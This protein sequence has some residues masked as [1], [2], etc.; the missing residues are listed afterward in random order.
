M[1]DRP[2]L[3][4]SGLI[5]ASIVSAF[6]RRMESMIFLAGPAERMRAEDRD[7]RM[8]RFRPLDGGNLFDFQIERVADSRTIPDDVPFSLFECVKRLQ[9]IA[10]PAVYPPHALHQRAT[11][12]TKASGAKGTPLIPSHSTRRFVPPTAWS[13]SL[14]SRPVIDLETYTAAI[15]PCGIV[16][17]VRPKPA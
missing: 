4:R 15:G 3:S 9:S 12:S 10:S 1:P 16:S 14:I 13:R 8:P 5:Q 11:E 2:A 7:T 17:H 6:V